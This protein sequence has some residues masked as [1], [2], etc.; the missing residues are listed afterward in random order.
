MLQDTPPVA[1]ARYHEL[2]RACAPHARLAQALALTRMVRALAVA[3]IRKRHPEAL[4]HEVRVRLAVR[5]YGR[6]AAVRMFREIPP[7]AR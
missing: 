3:G 7:D 6:D 4:E 1:F 5:L 2:L